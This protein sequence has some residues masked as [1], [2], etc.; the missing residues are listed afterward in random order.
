MAVGLEPDKLVAEWFHSKDDQQGCF[1]LPAARKGARVMEVQ[2]W[3]QFA[4]APNMP[5]TLYASWGFHV[6]RTYPFNVGSVREL[7]T[8]LRRCCDRFVWSPE[9][10]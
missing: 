5:G 4:G 3:R 8:Q 2:S 10:M 9:K 6:S 7:L 1:K